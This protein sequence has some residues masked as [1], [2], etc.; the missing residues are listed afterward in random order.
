MGKA[1]G[2]LK[3]L[4]GKIDLSIDHHP[5]NTGY[6][7]ATFLQPARASC[8]ELVLALIEATKGNRK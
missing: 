3:E 4:S 8:G 1:T 2:L 6:A 5:S 7:T